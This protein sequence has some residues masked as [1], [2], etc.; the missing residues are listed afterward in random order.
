MKD[1]AVAAADELGQLPRRQWKAYARRAHKGEGMKGFFMNMIIEEP[2]SFMTL[3]ARIMPLHVTT[4]LGRKW[5]TEEEAKAR[6]KERGL[7][8]S[9]L[10]F[11]RS[12]S[13][14]DLQEEELDGDPYDDPEAETDDEGLIDVTPKEAAE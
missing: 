9:T 8:E 14:D 2:K 10:N 11:V 4:N 3:M 12:I 7:P 6:L 13:E 1:A 5:L